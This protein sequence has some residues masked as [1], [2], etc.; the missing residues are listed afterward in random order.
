MSLYEILALVRVPS[1]RMHRMMER[2]CVDRTLK[3]LPHHGEVSA[4]AVERCGSCGHGS[5]CAD[6]LDHNSSRKC[7]PNTAEMPI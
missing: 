4:R 5:E 3:M 1:T 6:W 2:L 7:R